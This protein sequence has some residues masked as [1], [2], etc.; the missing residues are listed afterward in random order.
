MPDENGTPPV[1]QD[2]QGED[3]TPPAGGLDWE[4]WIADQA[5]EVKAAHE[6]Y[7]KGLRNT[8]EA[9]RRDNKELREAVKQAARGADGEVKAQL[10]A[11]S[12][13]L[14]ERER[15]VAFLDEAVGQKARKPRALWV[16]AVA[17]KAFDRYGKADWQYLR[18]TYGE[19]FDSTPAPRG[20]AGAGA[21]AQPSGIADMERRLR[22]AVGRG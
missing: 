21:G 5:P 15:E 20:N 9:T 4:S 13:R 14:Q 12:E 7:I 18:T 2:G 16:L 19:L 3:S 22:E 17:D 8:V 10:D 6:A 11:L 1:D